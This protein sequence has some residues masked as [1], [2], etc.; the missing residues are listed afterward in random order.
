[1][2]GMGS[3]W[4]RVTSGVPE[5]SVLGP[6]LFVIFINDLPEVVQNGSEI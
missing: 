4:R 3:E 5:D 6:L 1:M 2:N